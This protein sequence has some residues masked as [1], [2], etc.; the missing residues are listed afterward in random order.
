[1]EPKEIQGLD[2]LSEKLKRLKIWF[3]KHR[4]SSRVTLFLL[5]IASTVWF[6]IRVI[7]KP[8]RATYP[9]MRAAAPFMSAFVVYLLS[10]GGI[11]MALRRAKKH[12]QA[13]RYLPAVAFIFV[14]LCG[15]AAAFM[16]DSREARA[17]SVV[18][19]GPDDGPNQPMGKATGV[20]PGR[21]VWAWDPEATDENC[22]GYYYNPKYS[23]QEVIGN[24]FGE[25]VKKLA[26]EST[27]PEAWEALFRSFN[28]RKN[29]SDKGYAMGEKIFIKINQVMGQFLIK[30]EQWKDG[31]Y[32]ILGSSPKLDGPPSGTCHTTPYVALELLRHLVNHC[33]I[34][35]SD[36]AIGDP[37]NPIYGHNYD[38]WSAEFPDVVYIDRLYANPGRTLIQATTDDLLFYSDKKNTD[39]LYDIIEH[40]DYLINLAN[41]KPHV[42]AGI[43][44]TA[45]NH[46]G[47][48]SRESANHLHYSL[49]A[50]ITNGVPTNSGYRKYRAQVDMMGSKYLGGNTLLFI[51][52]GLFGGGSAEV[53]APVKYFMAPFN[54]D[55]SNSIFM[56]EDQVALESVCYDFL[57]TEWNGTNKHSPP[58]N[59]WESFV[60][61]NGVDDYLHQ[62]ADRSVWPEGINYDPDNS[63]I[64]LS[65]LGVHEHWNNPEKKQY[66]RNLG[67]SHGIELVSIPS[68]ITGQCK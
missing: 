48:Q 23:N 34:D 4:T 7:P 6:L 39:K 25:S 17:L 68:E 36:I 2:R 65:S 33:G 45:K 38:A 43:T 30:P 37:Q 35:P 61:V 29:Q 40:A 49:I 60:N 50:S 20:H 32:D 28:R 67:K 58:N 8:S 13:A 59:R 46:F 5:G 62:A 47:S 9:C 1:M 64:P 27:I 53:W 16:Q 10:L 44:L 3:R 11:T 15:M 54:N 24:M 51:V 55:Y 26:G 22:Q 41:F 31:D 21:V 12:I 42:K 19:T 18:S 57:R 56:S 66:S 63:G 14:A 52:D